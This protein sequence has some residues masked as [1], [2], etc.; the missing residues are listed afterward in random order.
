MDQDFKGKVALVTGAGSGIG[1]E[2]ARLFAARGAKVYG[3]DVNEKG[4]SETLD[5]ILKDGG[6]AAVARVDV[7]R[8]ADV[9]AFLKKIT[10]SAMIPRPPNCRVI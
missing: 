4:L 3:G 5:L 10:T 6:R 9:A 7:S 2:A 8:E 1:R